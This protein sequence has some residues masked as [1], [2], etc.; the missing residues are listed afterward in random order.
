MTGAQVLSYGEFL[1]AAG[2]VTRSARSEGGGRWLLACADPWGFA[3]GLFGLLQAG[4]DVLIPPNHLPA[5]LARL[6]LETDGVLATLGEPA[7]PPM[8]GPLG[9]GSL[10]FHTAGSSG[11]AKRIHKRLSQLN[12]EVAILEAV[13]GGRFQGG[14]VLATVPPH[15]IYGCLFRILWPLAAGR[16][17]A[18]ESWGDP[19]RFQP[20]PPGLPA[21][22]LVSSPAL[23]SRLHRLRDLDALA[24]IASVA[25]SSGGPLSAED[26][27]AWRR[28]VPG[29]VVEVYGSTES[30]G[31]AWRVQDGQP[32]SALWTPLPDVALSYAADGALLVSSPRVGPEPLRMEDAAEPAGVGRF[33]LKGRLDRL[34]KLEEK[35]ISLPELE[36]LLGAH[37]WVRQA[38]LVPLQGVRTTL[39]AV[40]VCTPE[41]S[42]QERMNQRGL[43]RELR[44]H[45]AA[46]VEGVAVPKRWRFVE[47]LPS[48]AAGKLTAAALAQLFAPGPLPW[49][50]DRQSGPEECFS[51][52]LEPGLT[53]FQGHFP[54]NPI[55]PGVVQVDWAIAF[56]RLAFGELG[57]FRGITG[58]KF[59]QPIRPGTRVELRLVLEPDRQRL[60]FQFTC[61][62]ARKSIGVVLFNSTEA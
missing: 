61:A 38:A 52:F 41:G 27:V 45:L 7:D 51:L 17:M 14:P 56:A 42:G 2:G 55:L 37:P 58:L 10:V 22:A 53:A 59:L 40:V 62:G 24:P 49:V 60:K 15:H 46:Q 16:P 29:G 30:G 19:A 39:G 32:E 50:L 47:E 44:R 21:P 8:A 18:L 35:R 26:A 13:F 57:G 20:L 5:T 25:F 4:C 36:A 31:I 6:A 1:R 11:E 12:A 9:D 3:A 54:G 34:L 23:L 33:Q 48:N 28:W 43:V